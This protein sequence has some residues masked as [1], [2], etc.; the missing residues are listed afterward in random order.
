MTDSDTA[1]PGST[2]TI[3]ENPDPTMPAWP[4]FHFAHVSDAEVRSWARARGI[5]VT[6]GGRLPAAVKAAYEADYLGPWPK[7][8]RITSVPGDRTDENSGAAE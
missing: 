1:T 8:F 7:V 6:R 2:F 4:Y 5:T 3:P